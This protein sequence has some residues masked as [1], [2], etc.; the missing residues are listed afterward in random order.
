MLSRGLK[1]LVL[2]IFVCL[3]LRWRSLWL[4][5]VLQMLEIVWG[6]LF[7]FQ[8]C[9]LGHDKKLRARGRYLLYVLQTAV[10][11]EVFSIFVERAEL[12]F[13]WSRWWRRSLLIVR[14][15]D[16]VCMQRVYWT[17]V[18]LVVYGCQFSNWAFF[19]CKWWIICQVVKITCTCTDDGEIFFKF[20]FMF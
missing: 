4:K 8:S 19:I 10:E 12:A 16:D 15:Y 18:A 2:R 5:A 9:C 13:F 7:L 11:F 3:L 6:Q 1:F 17:I 20:I 14:H